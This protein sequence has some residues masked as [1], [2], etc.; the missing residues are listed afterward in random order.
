MAAAAETVL[1]TGFPAFTARRMAR[2]IVESDPRARLFLLARGKFRAAAEEFALELGEAGGTGRVT[3][4]EG[5]VC[6]MDLGLAGGEYRALADELTSIYHLASIYYLGVKPDVARKVNVDGTRAMLE[7]AGECTR[8]RRF[9][10][11]STASVSGSRSGVIL[12]EE[13]D[14]GQRF[15]NAYE[16]TKLA[17]ERLVQAA[18][19]RLPITVLRPGEIVGDSKSGEIDKFDGPYFLIVLI[20]T[21]PLDVHLPLPGRGAAPMNL[22]PIDFVVDAAWALSRDPRAV[23]RTFHLTD[24]APFSSRSVY[25]LIAHRAERKPPRGVIPPALARAV[26]RA[27]GLASIARAPLA[28]LESFNQMTLYNCRGTLALLDGTGVRCPPLDAYVDNLVRYVREVQE[29]RRQKLEE[30]VFDPF[31]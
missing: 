23:G 31:E 17:G 24:P 15:R 3:V 13:L 30:E 12:E 10:H 27:P 20:V 9:T 6:D 8:L 2:K 22:V 26:L 29:A 1:L 7:L 25:E 28:F 5:D 14:E 11:F 16:E 21:S 18:S 19:R 4:L